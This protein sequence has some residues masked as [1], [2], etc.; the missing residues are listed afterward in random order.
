MTFRV[1]VFGGLFLA[2]AVGGSV[3]AS[4]VQAASRP[5]GSLALEN[6]DGRDVSLADLRG[7]VVVLNF[8]ATWCKPCLVEMPM[9]AKLAERY[10]ARGLRV[11]AASVDEAE[12]RPA[13]EQLADRLPAGMQV[14]VGATLADMQRLE[15]GEVVPVTV[16]IDRQGLAAQVHHGTIEDGDLDTLLDSLLGEFPGQENGMPRSPREENGM[17]RFPRKEDG[18]PGSP[19][20]EN[21]LPGVTEAGW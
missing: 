6:L 16:I 12:S 18:M 17:P 19:R 7:K 4:G 15:V 13:I 2:I 8:W 21:R 10:H 3:V 1:R 5:F 20:K 11:V 14:W 9:L